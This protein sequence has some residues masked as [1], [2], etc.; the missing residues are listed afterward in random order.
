MRRAAT[1]TVYVGDDSPAVS[2]GLSDPLRGD[3]TRVYVPSGTGDPERV[4]ASVGSFRCAVVHL[5]RRDGASDAIDAAELLRVYQP[6]LPI[7][8]LH[9]QASERLLQRGRVMGPLFHVPDE[10]AQAL[11][12]AREHVKKE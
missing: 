12:W 8:F 10:L 3:G 1:P 6:D 11:E 9:E 5:D 7:A 4:T 2:A